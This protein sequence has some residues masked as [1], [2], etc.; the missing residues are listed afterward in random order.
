MSLS[1]KVLAVNNDLPIRTDA[2][3]HSGKVRSVYW[4][5]QADS[6]R[7]I[8]E[9]GYNVPSDTALAIMVISDRISAFDCIWHGEGGMK[10]VPGKGAALNAISNHWFKLFKE[11]GL[12]DSHI[13]DIPHPFVWIVQKAQPVMIE[14]ICRQYITGSMWRSY[15]KGEREFCG[16]NLPEGLTKDSKLPTLLQTPSTKGILKGIP[17]VPE[18]DDVNITRKN[19]EDN[20]SAFNFKSVDDIG[21]YEKLLT[22]GFDVIASALAELD[23]IFIDTKFEFGYVKDKAGND[24]LIYMDEV[25]TPDSSRIWDGEEYRAGNVVENSKEGFRQLLL[26]HFPDPDILLNKDRMAE[27]EALARDNALPVDVL[28]NVSKTYIDIAEKVTGQ[29]IVLSDNPKAEI[30]DILRQQYQLID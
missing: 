5:T 1:D 22:Q 7:L 14:A 23:Q 2:P 8:E 28:M 26:N 27:R 29:K 21:L 19:I 30:V 10:G 15:A 16:I 12:A 6:K 4:L 20:F 13:L 11:Q 9:K 18:A 25:G 3:V 17:G 24:K